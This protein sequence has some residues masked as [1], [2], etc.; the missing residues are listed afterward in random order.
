MSTSTSNSRKILKTAGK[1]LLVLLVV[2]TAAVAFL[3]AGYLSAAHAGE[4]IESITFYSFSGEP[5]YSRATLLG[6]TDDSGEIALIREGMDRQ[7]VCFPSKD[8][9]LAYAEIL[10][11]DGSAVSCAVYE[12]RICLDHGRA[13]L[14]CGEMAAI[15]HD[16]L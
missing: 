5:Y 2:F 1:A 9:P 13:W 6:K 14:S 11:S 3:Q 7:K 16:F 4:D 8:E 10:Y 12:D 15:V